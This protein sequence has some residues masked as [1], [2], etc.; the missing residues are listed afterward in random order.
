VASIRIAYAWGMLMLIKFI[1]EKFPLLQWF[2]SYMADIKW[3]AG[4]RRTD[5]FSVL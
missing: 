1:E 4:K 3:N 2:K 5:S